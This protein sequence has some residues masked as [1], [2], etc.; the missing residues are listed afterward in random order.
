MWVLMAIIFGM[1][2]ITCLHA[3]KY[4]KY[5]S[6]LPKGSMGFPILGETNHFFAPN[7][8][9]D[10]SPFIK[11][12]VFKYGPIFKTSLV[13]KPLI[14]STDPDLNYLIFEQEETLFECWYPETFK[15]IFGDQFFGSLHGFMHK[16]LKNM[17]VNAFGIECLKSMVFEV[18]AAAITR[19]RRWASCEVVELKDEIANMILDLTAN[20]LI[21]YDPENS[22]ENLRENFVAFIQGLVSF[23]LDIPGTA[24]HKCLRGRK[25][26]MRMLEN[27]LE[28]R[29]Q[30]PRKQN[31]DFFDFVLQELQKDGTPLTK[32]IAL[33]LIFLL[34][35][36][37]YETTSIAL[38]LAIKFL[39]DHPHVL[40]Q[41]TEEHEGILKNR[42][43][44]ASGITWN[45]YKSMTFTFK[46]L[47]ETLRLANIAPGIF[48]RALRDVEF[49]GI[50]IPAGWG[51]MVCPPAIHLDP[52]HYV[53]PLAFNPWRWERCEGASKHFIAFGRGL[54]FCIG[55]DFAKLQMAVFLHN[56]VTKYRFKAIGGGNI[57]RT[58]GVQFPDGLHVEIVEK[59]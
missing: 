11:H 10:V 4:S 46:F 1:S 3:L 36:A 30:N 52:K 7:P 33:D 39:L 27:M 57:V 38:T 55:A 2:I 50:T 8:S 47:N 41:L 28:E 45:E 26:V 25:R 51:V 16:Y 37:S 35:F 40:S 44:K 49:K 9:F 23:P 22:P 56:L 53:D 21:S 14:I 32:E 54:R 15:K 34:L 48:R 13:G 29:Q 5:N 18:E 19:L 58:P 6:K 12:R 43:N 20:K 24:Y 59:E 17:I 42:K 31:V